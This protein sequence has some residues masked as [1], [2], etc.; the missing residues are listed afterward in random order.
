[1]ASHGQLR[2]VSTQ[3]QNASGVA[4]QLKGPSSMWLNWEDDGYAENLGG[5][6]T[7]RDDWNASLVRAAMGVTTSDPYDAD[8]FAQ[9]EEALRRVRAVVDHAIELGLYVIIDWHDH[10]AH[11]HQ[12]EAIA[13][14]TQMAG[15]YGHLPNVLYEVFN[16]PLSPDG[17]GSWNDVLKP[18]HEALTS[19]IRSVDPDNVIILGTPN[20]A[21]HVDTAAMDP[22]DP[23]NPSHVN[24]MY[25]LHFYAC[26]HGAELRE[27]GDAA[28]ALGLPLFVTEW[29]ATH[30]DGGTPD[31][32]GVC[33]E[34]AQ[35]WHDWMNEHAI[36]WAAWKWDNCQDA[37]CY[38]AE[39]G[40]DLAG[41]WSDDVLNGHG[42]FV[43]D[44]MRE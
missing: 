38:F 3:L 44:R 26:T 41:N 7:M 2:V 10:D 33:L 36:S 4:V 35:A 13:F 37:S 16:E 14:F 20:W 8:Y 15:E 30:A 5:L 39:E 25:T 17:D 1:M 27:R 23:T 18:Y 34:E 9:P 28:L 43:R 31:N 32:P 6:R 29:G 21:Q 11:L 19:A 22:L 12:S 24:L 40:A 42:S